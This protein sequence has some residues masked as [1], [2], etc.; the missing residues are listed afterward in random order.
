MYTTSKK[1]YPYISPFSP[2]PPI[3]VKTYSTPP[4]LYIGYQP[5]NLPQYPPKEA[6]YKGTLWPAFYDPY[7]NPYEK[8]MREDF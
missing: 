2:C 3:Q 5:Y 6:L 8:P 4:N 7:Y 1:Y